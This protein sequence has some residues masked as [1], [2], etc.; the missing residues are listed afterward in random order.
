MSQ[1]EGILKYLQRG[2]SLTPKSADHLFNC[3]R[4][5]ARIYE[6]KRRGVRIRTQMVKL[7]SGKR[8]AQYSL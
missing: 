6:L 8:V 5:G 7:S 1:T 4:L 3:M 2:R